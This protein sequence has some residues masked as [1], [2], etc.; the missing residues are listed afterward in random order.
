MK[1][2]PLCRCD[3]IEISDEGFAR[4]VCSSDECEF[5]HWNN[6]TPVV[7][8][9]V[10]H[11]DDIILANNFAWP[12]HVFSVITGFLEKGE[13]PED[14]TVREVDE[15]LG[16]KSDHIEAINVYPFFRMN[17][18]ILGY[19]VRA[20]GTVKL[21][22]ELRSYKHV[23]KEDVFTSD[24][25]TGFIL[26]DALLSQGYKPKEVS[27][28]GSASKKNNRGELYQ[29]IDAMVLRISSGQLATYGQIAKLVGGCGARQV[30]YAMSTLDDESEVPWHRVINSQ[31]RISARDGTEGHTLQRIILE[32][33]GV[34]FSK[35]GKVNLEI[36][37]WQG[38]NK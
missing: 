17:Q 20:S 19:Y 24:S 15:E 32:E 34:V 14:G 25:A 38:S 26:R 12:E 11:N 10:E 36:F 29:R 22:D 1:Y 33:E 30:G 28:F 16:L 2:C 35:K 31:G 4:L 9:V 27:F 13:S 5:I 37:R 3:L 6:P 21:N 18:L 8:A 23:K 7:A